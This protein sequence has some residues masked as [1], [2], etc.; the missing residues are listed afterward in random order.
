MHEYK[1]VLFPFDPF[2]ELFFLVF[3][4][5]FSFFFYSFL[6]QCR[7]SFLFTVFVVASSLFFSSSFERYF[8]FSFFF[9]GASLYL[10]VNR[11]LECSS[12]YGHTPS[13]PSPYFAGNLF[14]TCFKRYSFFFS[15]RC[16]FYIHHYI[17]SA[18][19]LSFSFPLAPGLREEGAEKHII[20]GAFFFLS[21]MQASH[22]FFLYSVLFRYIV[23]SRHLSKAAYTLASF[24]TQLSLFFSL[25]LFYC[26]FS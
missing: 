23:I 21:A 4:C 25:F 8:F 1:P 14:L 12:L 7:L 19:F 2:L 15:V 11:T 10:F 16:L 5:S 22:I 18:P 24:K 13:V 9:L 6:R 17:F 26:L 3:F 20:K